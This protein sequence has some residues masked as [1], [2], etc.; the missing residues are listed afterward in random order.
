MVDVRYV[1]LDSKFE[2][3]L[4][5]KEQRMVLAMDVEVG[6]DGTYMVCLLT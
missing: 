3:R 6:N 4:H 2:F 1:A 5:K